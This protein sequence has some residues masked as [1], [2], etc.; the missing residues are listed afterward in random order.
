MERK[1]SLFIDILFFLANI[2]LIF[3]KSLNCKELIY[4]I[5]LSLMKINF[6]DLLPRMNMKTN[7][8]IFLKKTYQN[9]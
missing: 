7:W 4:I 1:V 6:L 9:I 8:I 5:R 2:Y 3:L